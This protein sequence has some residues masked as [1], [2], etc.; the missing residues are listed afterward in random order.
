MKK[1]LKKFDKN[2]EKSIENLWADDKFDPNGS[3][4][5]TPVQDIKPVQDADDL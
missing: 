2:K 3:Y 4:V 1:N 5:G